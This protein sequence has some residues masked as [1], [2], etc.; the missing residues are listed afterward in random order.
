M[1]FGQE[2]RRGYCIA[3]LWNKEGAVGIKERHMLYTRII[4]YL[5]SMI[6][7]MYWSFQAIMY[8]K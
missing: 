6:P 5:E 7:N 8:T 2:R 3:S 4:D 1:G